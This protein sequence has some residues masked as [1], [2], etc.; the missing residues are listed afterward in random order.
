MQC[1]GMMRGSLDVMEADGDTMT[2]SPWRHRQY[3]GAWS[4]TVHKLS[5]PVCLLL[6]AQADLWGHQL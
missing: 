6:H 5:K 3:T 4:M 2:S 1:S